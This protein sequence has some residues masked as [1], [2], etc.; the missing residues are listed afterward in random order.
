MYLDVSP[1]KVHLRENIICLGGRDQ[2]KS[3]DESELTNRLLNKTVEI[4]MMEGQA[5]EID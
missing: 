2:M 1:R 4:E 3:R 5:F